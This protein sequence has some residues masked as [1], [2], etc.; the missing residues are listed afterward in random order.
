MMLYRLRQRR[1]VTLATLLVWWL[2][3]AMAVCFAEL[4]VDG[5][6]GMVPSDSQVAAVAAPA[7]G[8][9]D[10][11]ATAGEEH[12]DHLMPCHNGKMDQAAGAEASST[13][14]CDQAE[15]LRTDHNADTEFPV[16]LPS[17][18]WL[19]G[20]EPVGMAFYPRSQLAF[21]H[22]SLPRLHVLL[23]VFLD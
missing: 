8:G 5:N 10:M 23:N 19:A 1:T 21:L 3:S 20:F 12:S 15:L 9:P 6:G 4:V 16:T 17:A 13:D 18:S 22:Q 7:S 14:C 11:H 2:W